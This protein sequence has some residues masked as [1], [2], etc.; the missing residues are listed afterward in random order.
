MTAKETERL[1]KVE[2]KMD[3]MQ[4]EIHEIKESLNKFIETADNK[5]APKDQFNFWRNVL[6]SGILVTIMIG[7]I[8][9]LLLNIYAN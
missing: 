5:Y 3:Y 1:T 6:I 8:N 2:T 9:I 7:V 4:D